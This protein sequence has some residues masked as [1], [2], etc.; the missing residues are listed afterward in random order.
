MARQQLSEKKRREIE[1]LVQAWGRM[2]AR[3]VCPKGPGLTM[4]MF[5]MEE[6]AATAAKALVKG[7]VETLASDQADE[8]GETHA[9]PQCGR[10]CPLERRSR[11][12][13]VRG[14]TL[15]L[16]EPVA[17]CSTC[18]RDFFPSASGTE[19]RRSSL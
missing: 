19:S 16:Q 17:H 11:P 1:E 12:M 2:L 10:S 18:R 3:E 14:G 15:N 9:C 7:T 4:D 6:I 8:L 5:E 13:Q